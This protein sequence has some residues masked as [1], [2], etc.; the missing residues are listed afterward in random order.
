M[1]ASQKLNPILILP[2]APFVK[3]SRLLVGLSGGSDSTALLSLLL[4]QAAPQGVVIEAAHVNYHLRGRESLKDE[5]FVKALC[6]KLKVRLSL[7]RLKNVRLEAIRKKKSLQDWA[8]DRRYVFFAQLCRDRRAWGAAVAHQ[9]DD[10]AETVMDRLLRGAGS[11]GLTGLREVQELRFSKPKAQ[12]KIWR[13]LLCFSREELKNYLRAQSLPWREDSS[14]RKTD[15]RRNQIRHQVLPFLARWNPQISKSLFKIGEVTAAQ[16]LFLG[17]SLETLVKRM[18]FRFTRSAG[19]RGLKSEFV[20][21]PLALQRLWVREVAE[22]LSPKAR[23][24]SFDRLEDALRVWKGLKKG[25]CDLGR[26]LSVDCRDGSV[27]MT[28][29]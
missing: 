11:R 3:K 24:L 1:K 27:F 25:P 4:K 6:E 19:Y 18:K 17:Q 9:A 13:P 16:D 22:R 20:R 29:L 2:P 8:R 5:A 28:V 23:G 21:M 26:G 12:L 15:Y 7:L 10:Q 14:N